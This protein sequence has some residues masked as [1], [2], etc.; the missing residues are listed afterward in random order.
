MIKKLFQDEATELEKKQAAVL[1]FKH[2]HIGR[3]ITTLTIGTLI[4]SCTLNIV[5]GDY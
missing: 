3:M 4:V 5:S 2:Q 1:L